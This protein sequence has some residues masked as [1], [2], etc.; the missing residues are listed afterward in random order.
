[1]NVIHTYIQNSAQDPL[2]QV[3]YPEYFADN[4]LG[5]T[6][7]ND[8]FRRFDILSFTRLSSQNTF[9]KFTIKYSLFHRF[10]I[11]LTH[12]S[13]VFLYSPKTSENLWFSDVFW[14]YR[15]ATLN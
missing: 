7:E 11:Q 15:N 1:M 6:I 4:Q 12:F 10:Y 5:K 3:I 9:S 8:I 2:F 13:P 14:G